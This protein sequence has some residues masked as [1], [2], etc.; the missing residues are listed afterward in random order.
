MLCICNNETFSIYLGETQLVSQTGNAYIAVSNGVIG[1]INVM[2]GNFGT[3]NP[4]SVINYLGDV[5]W[6]DAEHGCWTQY[7]SNGVLPINYK[8]DSYYK[9]FGLKYSKQNSTSRIIS[10]ID[11]VRKQLIA[12]MP[13][14][15]YTNY[16]YQ[17]PSY[18]SSDEKPAYVSTLNSK[19]DLY[20]GFGKMFFMD[21]DKNKWNYA[22][23]VTNNV[24]P[25]SLIPAPDQG[26]IP[27]ISGESILPEWLEFIDNSYYS[28]INGTQE[29]IS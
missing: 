9:K 8:L 10:G 7:A 11:P 28:F 13:S 17:M 15:E 2:K 5:F 25:P 14:T 29:P 20:D 19:F 22:L 1:T 18:G 21:I 3:T 27:D 6:Y 24:L 16:P 23:A 4:E 26:L 12:A